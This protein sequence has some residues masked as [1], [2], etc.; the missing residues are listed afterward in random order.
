M[1]KNI[2]DAGWH[3]FEEPNVD[4]RNGQIDMGHPF[5]THF[6]EGH[7][8]AAAV[9]NNTFVLDLLIF[10]ASAFPIAG[11]TKDLLAEEAPLFWFESTIVDRLRFFD[12]PARPLIADHIIRCDL[13]GQL[14][15]LRIV[16][17]HLELLCH[18]A[19]PSN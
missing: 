11:R 15:E 14:I 19:F 16:N 9:A 13:D 17:T 4:D 2:S 8:D 12:F 5:A 10:T 1:P 6:G 18:H 7:F 3:R